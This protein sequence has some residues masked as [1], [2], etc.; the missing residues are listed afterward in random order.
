MTRAGADNKYMVSSY[1]LPTQNVLAQGGTAV[2]T[3]P[4]D[5]FGA[6]AQCD[7][8]L[9]FPSTEET[10]FPGFDKPSAEGTNHLLLS[11]HTATPHASQG[12]IP[13]PRTLCVRRVRLTRSARG[14]LPT[15]IQFDKMYVGAP[16][17]TAAR[18]TVLLDHQLRPQRVW[19]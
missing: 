10:T 9:C 12:R 18:L 14:P 6:Y 2:Y 15:A 8:G 19:V 16:I 17:G 11:D 13:N 4:G 5:T 1:S 7:G 3:C